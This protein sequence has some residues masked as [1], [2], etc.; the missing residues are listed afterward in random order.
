MTRIPP[1]RD[2]AV[3]ILRDERA[4]VLALLDALPPPAFTRPGLGGGDWSPKDLLGHLE[5]WEEH[6]LGALDAWSRGERAPIDVALQTRGLTRVNL[7][8]V[9]RKA[10]RTPA[11]ARSAAAATHA[12]LLSAIGAVPPARW[13][14]PPVPR[15]RL[16]LGLKVGRILAGPGLFDHDAAHLKDLRAFVAE[17][18]R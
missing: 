4:R 9:A 17:H 11:A 7:D 6:A 15:A 3:R 8:E 13:S 5:S 18:G 12:A 16:S 1:T 14:A 2:Q 10:A